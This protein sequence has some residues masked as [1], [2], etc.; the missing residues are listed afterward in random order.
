MVLN[1]KDETCAV[2]GEPTTIEYGYVV[3]WVDTEYSD[4]RIEYSSRYFCSLECVRKWSIK[5]LN[6]GGLEGASA[7]P[8]EGRNKFR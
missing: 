5:I 4:G 6:E 3:N 8:F 7:T 2:C 1:L